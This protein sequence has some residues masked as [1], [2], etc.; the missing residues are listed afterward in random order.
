M[1]S[2]NTEIYCTTDEQLTPSSNTH[3]NAWHGAG[4]HGMRM[5]LGVWYCKE[6]LDPRV[7]SFKQ[8]LHC[9]LQVFRMN[10]REWTLMHSRGIGA[11]FRGYLHDHNQYRLADPEQKRMMT[12]A[13]MHAD[14]AKLR[15]D[16][17][18]LCFN[19]HAQRRS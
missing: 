12:R 1:S 6:P 18:I 17:C 11:T 10:M 8:M 9:M 13:T 4:A 16:Q 7:R 3:A 15:D 14:S 19:E 2:E 5:T